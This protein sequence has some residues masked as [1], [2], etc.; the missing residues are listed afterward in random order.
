MRCW[1][2]LLANLVGDHRQC[3]SESEL[4]FRVPLPPTLR[5]RLVAGVRK[6]LNLQSGCAL[7]AGFAH[8]FYPP[9]ILQEKR[10]GTVRIKVVA[11]VSSTNTPSP[12]MVKSVCKSSDWASTLRRTARVQRSAEASPQ[13]MRAEERNESVNVCAKRRAHNLSFSTQNPADC[14]CAALCTIV[15]RLRCSEWAAGLSLTVTR[16]RAAMGGFTQ[17]G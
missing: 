14:S 5:A 2:T 16:R 4:Q 10:S 1:V 11:P 8:D 9:S 7:V 3:S 15:S 13:R 6:F 17:D 12:S